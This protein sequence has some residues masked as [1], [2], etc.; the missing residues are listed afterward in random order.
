MSANTEAWI[1][2][3]HGSRDPHWAASIESI[4]Q[5]IAKKKPGVRCRLAFMEMMKPSLL[6]ALDDFMTEGKVTRFRIFPLFLSGGGTHMTRD[7][8]AQIEAARQRFPSV[9]FILNGALGEDASVQEA[10]AHA[11]VRSAE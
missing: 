6:E 5:R 11:V 3:A 1:V 7:I 2:L 10:I 8:P 4:H 9:E